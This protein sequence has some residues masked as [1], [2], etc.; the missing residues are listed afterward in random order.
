MT[1][2]I[3]AVFEDFTVQDFLNIPEDEKK[4]E[5]VITAVNHCIRMLTILSLKE[6]KIYSG[7]SQIQNDVLDTL[8]IS[9]SE[10]YKNIEDYKDILPTHRKVY[11]CYVDDSTK[12]CG[13]LT[14]I[15]CV[16]RVK[17]E[18]REAGYTLTSFGKEMKNKVIPRFILLFLKYKICPS[19]LGYTSSRKIVKKRIITFKKD[20]SIKELKQKL[21]KSSYHISISKVLKFLDIIKK[22][23][24]ICDID[25][26][27]KEN[28]SA[29]ELRLILFFLKKLGVIDVKDEKSEIRAPLE[30]Y[31]ILKFLFECYKNGKEYVT[32]KEIE[33]KLFK[34]YR[35]TLQYYIKNF[36]KN[37]IIIFNFPE[38]QVY[39]LVRYPNEEEIK[40]PYT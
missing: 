4:R 3:N 24:V 31:K 14:R 11:W 7:G 17:I 23:K 34:H 18:G 13:V 1:I 27:K 5:I 15:N 38:K 32:I 25:L 8:G 20:V 40:S 39:T 36:E 30:A 2:T 21:K 6:G 16:T 35:Y 28:F 26:I 19:F 12:K 22:E 10:F 29:K 37:G 9:K 33:T